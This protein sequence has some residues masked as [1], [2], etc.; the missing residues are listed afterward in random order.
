MAKRGK[1][2]TREHKE[3]LSGH[4]KVPSQWMFV[5]QVNESYMQFRNIET[6]KII[7]LDVYKKKRR[8]TYADKENECD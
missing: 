3:I 2:L 7:N 5:K 1:R 8:V 4:G 6:G